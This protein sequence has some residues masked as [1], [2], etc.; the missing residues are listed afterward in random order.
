MIFGNQAPKFQVSA[1][2]VLLDYAVI[3]VDDID[4]ATLMNESKLDRQRD[5]I[6]R[7]RHH[8]FQVLI[9]LHRYQSPKAKFDEI[10]AHLGTATCQLWRHRDAQAF[11]DTGSNDANFIFFSYQSLYITTTD[12]ADGLRLVFRSAEA[13]DHT[14]F[15]D[16]WTFARALT[17]S[18]SNAWYL[19]HTTGLMTA[20]A[21]TTTARRL[22]AG[23]YKG[24]ALV[25][26]G[27]ATNLII[28]PSGPFDDGGANNWTATNITATANTGE[29]LDLAGT[30]IADKLLTTSA[31]GNIL[32][33]SGTAVGND[34]AFAIWLKSATGSV[35]G[36][37]DI[38]GDG[39]GTS[40]EAITVTPTWQKFQMTQDT[41]APYS[42]NLDPKIIIT[43]DATTVYAWGAGLYDS[44]EFAPTIIDPTATASKTRALEK[45][46]ILSA[47]T[48]LT[49]LKGTVS[50]WVKPYFDPTA[51]SSNGVLFESGDSAGADA[52]IH[53]RLIYLGTP[54]RLK[55]LIKGDNAN[56]NR[57]DYTPGVATGMTQDTW[58]HVVLIWDST[59]SNGG[60][61]Y[62]NGAELSTGS[63]N[64]AFNVSETG[65]TIALGSEADSGSRADGEYDELFIDS[66]VW[67]AA[68]V[69]AVYNLPNGLD[70]TLI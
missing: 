24:T 49:K 8:I 47:N 67:T 37:I 60:H 29:T 40:P 2:D 5:F 53:V 14:D 9:H 46:T 33:Q 62:I 44:S 26:E 45:F 52:D 7:P 63:S 50:F 23:K 55:L 27:A 12:Y 3:E 10:V 68:K 32:Y 39:G 4:Y 38:T 34:A 48:N 28:E 16:N 15:G 11:Q 57:I 43:P 36:F 19:H 18:V 66:E 20:A 41:T 61:I 13:I 25:I 6:T 22:V 42:G 69:L 54:D 59:I 17:S 31:N 21:D 51:H 56:T 64:S 65:D 58:A 30:S 35:A 1:T 70:R